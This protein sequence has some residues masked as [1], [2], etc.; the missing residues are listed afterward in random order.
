MAMISRQLV[1]AID[2]VTHRSHW[3]PDGICHLRPL[4]TDVGESFRLRLLGILT[5]VLPRGMWSLLSCVEKTLF[6]AVQI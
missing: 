4:I 6:H 2:N 3:Q 5:C 1:T